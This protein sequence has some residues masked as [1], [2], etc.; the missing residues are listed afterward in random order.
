M[1]IDLSIMDGWI[2][3]LSSFFGIRQ[4]HGRSAAQS[5]RNA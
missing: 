2:S 5:G 1:I 4:D 3:A